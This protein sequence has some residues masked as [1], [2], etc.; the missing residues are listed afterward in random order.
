[1]A[2]SNEDISA[3]LGDHF[4]AAESFQDQ[5]F[6]ER[7]DKIRDYYDGKPFGTEQPDRSK[8]IL[9][10]V[11]DKV[12]SLLPSLMEIFTA[13]HRVAKFAPVG[14]EDRPAAEQATDYCNHI[15]LE[16]NNGF[17]IT[18]TF[19]K[20]A[21]IDIIGVTKVFVEEVEET[22]EDTRT[23]LTQAEMDALEA[24]DGVEILETEEVET[25]LGTIFNAKV[26]TTR[27]AS[28]IIVRNVDPDHFYVSDSLDSIDI[29]ESI[30]VAE[31]AIMFASDLIEMGID[32]DVVAGLPAQDE[33]DP[34][35]GD[36]G[37]ND[38][39]TTSVST[40]ID[41]SMKKIR[42][43]DHY[44]RMDVD[45]TGKAQRWK[46]L[47]A[48]TNHEVL[49]KEEWSDPWPYQV[50]TPI[51][52]THD[53]DGIGL[54]EEVADIQ[55]MKSTMF[56]QLADNIYGINNNRLKVRTSGPNQIDIDQVLSNGPGDVI[57][58]NAPQGAADVEALQVQPIGDVILPVLEWLDNVAEIRTGVTRY[59][60]GL[61]SEAL[62]K[63]L[64]GISRIM[65][66]AHAKQL[67]IARIMA[68]TGLKKIF[69]HIYILARKYQAGEQ[70]I[71]L[72][73]KFIKMDTGKWPENFDL[74][75]QVGLGAGNKVEQA[76]N[77][78][79]LLAL[80][81]SAFRQGM[82]S[83]DHLYNA[84][85]QVVNAMGYR[86]ASQFAYD[87]QT[88]EGQRALQQLAQQQQGQEN[89]A[90]EAAKI[91]AQVAMADIERKRQADEE[92]ALLRMAEM[93][94]EAR[95]ENEKLINDFNLD[96]E[97][98]VSDIEIANR[99]L[100]NDFILRSADI[101]REAVQEQVE[102]E[103]ERALKEKELAIKANLEQR[104]QNIDVRTNIRDP[105]DS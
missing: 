46:F 52:K 35:D 2:L 77:A 92:R 48:G 33:V 97:K 51:I 11:R 39:P 86:D 105:S 58:I 60:Q 71:R 30:Y 98:L 53:F 21:L 27:L 1:M 47:T 32:E 50:T 23:G 10:D 93:Q 82:A 73:N 87:P 83:P 80:T 90:V 55:L 13:G 12:E 91:Q 68:E 89:P 63:T 26:Q 5:C 72:R 18:Y 99:K 64:G 45:E 20:D 81:S 14:P 42:V 102:M 16:Q 31:E 49:D 17:L 38:G 95:I 69:E 40:L 61:D 57:E 65:S 4:M 100:L 3:I 66:A 96:K 28:N 36:R 7:R 29:Q 24:E 8:A 67:L 88:P 25:P 70:V 78:G 41:P 19:C 59:N 62:N 43:V 75:V 103:I 104:K 94:E 15:F 84:F 56:R 101:N 6:R 85:E 76:Q 34:A 74:T 44:I 22:K 37:R 9:T 79:Q 54:G